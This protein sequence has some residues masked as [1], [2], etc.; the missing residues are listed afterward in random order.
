LVMSRN[1]EG[2]DLAMTAVARRNK[3]GKNSA[4]ATAPRHT[5]FDLAGLVA[6]IRPKGVARMQA[7]RIINRPFLCFV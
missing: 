4:F 5:V 7:I 3:V 1:S 6:A 2:A